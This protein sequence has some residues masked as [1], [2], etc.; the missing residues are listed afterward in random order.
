MSKKT[1]VEKTAEAM[2]KAGEKLLDD[3]KSIH[4]PCNNAYKDNR[5]GRT[6]CSCWRC[7]P[8]WV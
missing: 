5:D 2:I 6:S 1:D 7:R 3:A 4:A 8:E